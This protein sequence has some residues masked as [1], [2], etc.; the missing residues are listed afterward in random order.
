MEKKKVKNDHGNAVEKVALFQQIVFQITIYNPVFYPDFLRGG[1]SRVLLKI[2]SEDCKMRLKV[3][4]NSSNILN[5]FSASIAR[6]VIFITS[7]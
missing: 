3:A 7:A 2:F 1:K 6:I 5:N 4:L